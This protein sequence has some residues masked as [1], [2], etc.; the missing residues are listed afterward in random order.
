MVGVPR[1]QI[2]YVLVMGEVRD[3]SRRAVGR[4]Q[5]NTEVE[6]SHLYAKM[7]IRCCT[8]SEFSCVFG[9]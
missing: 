5:L 4:R 6:A 2:L 9:F 7:H 1:L 8:L 3:T